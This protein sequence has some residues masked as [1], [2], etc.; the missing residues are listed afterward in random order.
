MTSFAPALAA[1]MQRMPVPH[2]TS[3]T[4]LPRTSEGLF[5]RKSPYLGEGVR[6]RGRAE[7]EGGGGLRVREGAGSE[8]ECAE[9]EGETWD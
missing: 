6:V 4:T 1:N 2:P 3:S 9:S 8:G 5:I 7:S